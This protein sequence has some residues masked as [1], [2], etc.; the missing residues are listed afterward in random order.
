MAFLPTFMP[1]LLACRTTLCLSCPA[2]TVRSQCQPPLQYVYC[3]PCLSVCTQAQTNTDWLDLP[4]CMHRQYA[5]LV[6]GLGLGRCTWLAL[7]AWPWRV[8]DTVDRVGM[9]GV[10]RGQTPLPPITPPPLPP[11]IPMQTASE[12][13]GHP[14]PRIEYC[15]AFWPM[16][17]ARMRLL[18][19]LA[20]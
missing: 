19:T 2:C 15:S 1:W 13:H 12:C 10:R 18:A 4:Y 9:M 20:C 16:W 11:P 3:T 17:P 5:V 14:H 8:C 6:K 7:Y